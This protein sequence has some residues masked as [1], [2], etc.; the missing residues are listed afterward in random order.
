MGERDREVSSL[1]SKLL[2]LQVDIKNLHD[3]C[4]R[5]GMTLQE[6]QLSVEEAMMN[7]GHVRVSASAIHL[8]FP[9]QEQS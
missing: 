8:C 6:S 7:S 1:N 5:Q 4:K 3:V 2:S 9:G